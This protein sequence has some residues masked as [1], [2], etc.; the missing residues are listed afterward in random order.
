MPNLKDTKSREYAEWVASVWH[1]NHLRNQL[2]AETEKA[3]VARIPHS[4][5]LNPRVLAIRQQNSK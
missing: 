2:I 4:R 1:Y 5:G 3:R